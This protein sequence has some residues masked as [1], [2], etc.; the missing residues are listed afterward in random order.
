MIEYQNVIL[1][2][3][4]QDNG[5]IRGP[6][7]SALKRPEMQTEGIPVYE[8]QHAIYNSR[9]FRFFISEE[10]FE[11]LKRFQVEA[12][13][14]VISCSGTVGR[15]T[16]IKEED[17]KG[18]ISQALLILRVDSKKVLPQ[19][20][21]Y[22]FTSK[23]GYN[24]IVS[25]SSGSVQVNI[26][27]RNVIEQ[28][29]LRLPSTN[30]QKKIVGVLSSIDKKI[31]KNEQI[32][33]NLEEQAMALFKSWFVDFEPFDYSM[34]SDW[35]I[36]TLD[37]IADFQN[38]YAFKSKELLNEPSKDTYQV[39]KQGHIN[40]GG[41]FLPNGTKS[42]YQ[43]SSA[44]NL[45]KFILKKGDILMAM[46]DMK[47]NVAILGNTAIMP[48]DDEFIVNQRV[49]HLRANGYKGIT[50]PYIYLLTN[51]KDFLIDL[52]SRANS[53]V[54]VNLSSAE[55]KSS[56]IV[57]ATEETN[58]RFSV[59]VMPMFEQIIQNQLENQRLSILRD[60]LLPKL[61]S[62]ELDVS[63]INP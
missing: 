63:D 25:R 46:T 59:I 40:R 16:I 54:Q 41:G 55:I 51:S 6:F 33:N 44:A 61:M 3:L 27:K 52:R 17:P 50:Y 15:V 22:F 53:G 26:S 43:K 32:N 35:E 24:A 57:I 4:L 29:P 23:E 2:D 62:G 37:T 31:E 12:N 42:W 7:G 38:G 34:P 8:Q 39:F 58:K 13:D 49:G 47:D 45:S 28:I 18:I 19:Y 11:E 48:V 10:K 30:I 56:E 20:L 36:T 1:A 21:K 5:Y 14:L 60:T 9:E